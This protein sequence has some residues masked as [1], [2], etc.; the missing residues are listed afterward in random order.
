MR[1]HGAAALARPSRPP[2]DG[3][4]EFNVQWRPLGTST[5][6][7]DTFGEDEVRRDTL[8]RHR[9]SGVASETAEG[10]MGSRG[11]KPQGQT[12]GTESDARHPLEGLRW[13]RNPPSSAEVRTSSAHSGKGQTPTRRRPEH[14]GSPEA[15]PDHHG[16]GGL[17]PKVAASHGIAI[18]RHGRAAEPRRNPRCS[19]GAPRPEA[20]D[21]GVRTFT[22]C[23]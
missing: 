8:D 5:R 11:A 6:R 16:Q 15:T 14:G 9:R 3:S 21:C 1:R 19:A 2:D 10:S 12:V 4:W 7:I 18:Q 20:P 17:A 22:R 13:G 23:E